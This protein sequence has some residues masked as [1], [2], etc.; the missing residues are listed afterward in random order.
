MTTSD[1][2]IDISSTRLD[3]ILAAHTAEE[4]AEIGE[5]ATAG[6]I[7]AAVG[8][9]DRDL[10]Q[11]ASGRVDLESPTAAAVGE[12]TPFDIASITKALVGSVLA[13][14][15]VDDG[16]VGWKTPI[17][18]I[19]PAWRERSDAPSQKATFLQILNHT[20]GLPAW[21]EFYLEHPLD[22][23][24]ELAEKTRR[25]VLDTII[26]MPLDGVP[27]SVHAYSDLGYLL[28]AHLLEVI[29]DDD[30][31]DLAQKRIFDPLDL[32]RTTY[33][34]C[35]DTPPVLAE[36]VVTEDCSRRGR[37]VRGTVHDENTNIIGGVSTHAGVFST[38]AD[39]LE[40]GRHLLAIDQGRAV[41][42]PL[43][44]RETLQFA[45]SHEAGSDV[46]HHLAGWDTPSG[47]RSSAGRGFAPEHTVGHLGFT[48]TSLWIERNHGVISVLLSNRVYPTRENQCIKDLRVQFQ[49]AVLIPRP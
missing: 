15:A 45:W 42:N 32:S 22:P 47:N 48:G 27:G 10:Y 2:V 41:D 37:V 24:P 46:G 8:T 16:L 34:D 5:S 39:L 38:A 7:Q 44:S 25:V 6:A 13:M 23:S 14:Q 40:F 17:A 28:L 43:V 1:Q 49:E 26:N 35:H 4:R 36:A 12:Q 21:R 20:S 30:L 29:F 19:L 9:L 11:R 33:A 3:A 18:D 31:R